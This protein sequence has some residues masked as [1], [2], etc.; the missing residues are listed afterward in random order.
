MLNISLSTAK[1]RIKELKEKGI[2]E[3]IGID[4]TGKWIIVEK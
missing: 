2:I 4:K 3:R 1:R